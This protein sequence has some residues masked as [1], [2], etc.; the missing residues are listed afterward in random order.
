[1]GCTKFT[2]SGAHDVIAITPPRKNDLCTKGYETLLSHW[3]KSVCDL[4]NLKSVVYFSV[5][6]GDSGA[7][8]GIKFHHWKL[9]YNRT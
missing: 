4:E 6:K 9:F 5:E 8:A 3:T 1:M 7:D 2:T